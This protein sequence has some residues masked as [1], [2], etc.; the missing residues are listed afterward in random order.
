MQHTCIVILVPRRL[1]ADCDCSVVLLLLAF[2]NGTVSDSTDQAQVDA[3]FKQS[4]EAFQHI[5]STFQVEFGGIVSESRHRYGYVQSTA[6]IDVV[7]PVTGTVTDCVF[8]GGTVCT[9]V[10]FH[11]IVITLDQGKLV[12]VEFDDDNSLCDNDHSVDGNCAQ[13][14]TSCTTSTTYSKE[15]TAKA[16]DCDFKVRQWRKQRESARCILATYISFVTCLFCCSTVVRCVAWH[17]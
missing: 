5:G 10:P 15:N 14:I 9:I 16:T 3:Y 2:T 8:N 11:T 7:D 4:Y 13:D 12:S 6:C 17:G 1:F